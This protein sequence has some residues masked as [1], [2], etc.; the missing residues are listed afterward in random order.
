MPAKS[1][2][3]APIARPPAGGEPA[4]RRIVAGARRYFFAHGFRGVTMDDLAAELAMSKKTLYAH[5]PEQNGPPPGSHLRQNEFRRSR[6]RAR[7]RREWQ[8]FSCPPPSPPRLHAWSHRRNRR[9]L[10]PGCPSRSAGTLRPGA[11]HGA[12]SSSSVSSASSSRMAARPAD[13]QGH[14]RD[15]DDRDAARRGR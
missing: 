8:R 7:H 15:H 2:S 5:F 6:P 11:S 4:H 10:R 1:L 3:T 13:S 12:A 14:P 9:R